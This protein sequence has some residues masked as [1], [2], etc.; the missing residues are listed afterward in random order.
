M[1]VSEILKQQQAA[2]DSLQRNLAKPSEGGLTVLLGD[3][4]QQVTSLQARIDDLT[5]QQA[6]AMQRFDAAI[7]QHKRALAVVQSAMATAGRV[8]Q[9]SAPPA[10]EKSS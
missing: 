7:E 2:L 3:R 10:G 5:R 8:L 6:A 9:G 4:N 1:D